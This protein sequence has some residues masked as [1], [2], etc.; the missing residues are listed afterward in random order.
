MQ[1]LLSGYG[2]CNERE[3]PLER[4]QPPNNLEYWK[5]QGPLSSMTSSSYNHLC[6]KISSATAATSGITQQYSSFVFKLSQATTEGL[7]H[8]NQR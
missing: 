8:I 6:K 2:L 7:I 3:G 4:E 1:S 5:K